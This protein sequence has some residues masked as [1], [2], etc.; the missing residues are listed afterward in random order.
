MK[1]RGVAI[2][3]GMVLSYSNIAHPARVQNKKYIREEEEKI[4]LW[5][6]EDTHSSLGIHPP[7]N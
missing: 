3:K 7:R 1:E 6:A 2:R 4:E 5:E